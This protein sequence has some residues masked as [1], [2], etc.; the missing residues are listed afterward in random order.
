MG[1]LGLAAIIIISLLLYALVYV[2]IKVG[3]NAL[4]KEIVRMHLE[5]KS[6]I[7]AQKQEVALLKYRIRRMKHPYQEDLK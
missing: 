2:Y 7:T 1:D 6:E 5:N 4:H 3:I